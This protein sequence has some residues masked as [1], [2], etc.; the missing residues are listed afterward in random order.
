MNFDPII[1]VSFGAGLAIVLLFLTLA[2]LSGGKRHKQFTARLAR[3]QGYSMQKVVAGSD[4]TLGD[5][6]LQGKDSGF[7]FLDRLIKRYLP[8]AVVLRQ[9]LECTGFKVSLGEYLLFALVIGTCFGFL[10]HLFFGRSLIIAVLSGLSAALALPHGMVN[11]LIAR[12]LKAFTAEF[13]EAIDLIV[14][15]LKSG[16][17]VP[18]SIL[19]VSQEI[20]DPVGCEFASVSDRLGIGQS[21]EEALHLVAARVPTAEFRFFVTSLA[22]QRETGGNLAETLENL[23]DVLRKRRQMKMKVKAMSSEA[24]ASALIL[25]S[26]PFLMFAIMFVLNPEYVMQLFS[27]A[28]GLLMIGAGFGSLGVGVLV[29]AKMV[30]FEI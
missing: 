18:A 7:R 28:R 11:F 21:L 29:M 2:G 9:R 22:V 27:D 10:A 23:S 25:G 13:P 6:R 8:R 3:V 30:R 1:I 16:L 5:I 14:R 19:S 12:R 26:L 15:G 17:P 24:K 4:A 20:R